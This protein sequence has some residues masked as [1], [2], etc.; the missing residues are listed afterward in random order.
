MYACNMYKLGVSQLY[1]HVTTT[2]EA[3]TRITT[4]TEITAI[5]LF[6]ICLFTPLLLLPI[7]VK[8]CHM[9]RTQFNVKHCHVYQTQF[10]VKHCH[11]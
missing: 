2:R 5:I 1:L 6:H 11:M 8:H 4:I 3:T 9:Y 7:D 10:N